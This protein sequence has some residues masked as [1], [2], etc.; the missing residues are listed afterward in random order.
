[1]SIGVATYPA[2]GK[3]ARTL[4]SNADAALYR[5]KAEGPGS[6]FLF[7]AEMAARLHDRAALEIELRSAIQREEFRLHYQPQ[8]KMTGE[9]V[10]FEALARWH[11]PTRGSV[12][13]TTFIP[14]A[15]ESSLILA[16]GEWV[17]RQACREAAS[18][19]RP[20]RVA[21]N[22][23]PVQFRHGDLA[24][25][26]HSVLLETGLASCRLEL[27][28]TE[29]VLI[30]DFSRA[31]SILRRIKS[32]GVQ[33]VL[34]DFGSKYSSLSYLRAFPF[35]KIKIDRSFISNLES[36]HQSIAIVRAIIGLGHGL[37]IPVLAEGVETAVQHAFLAQEGCDEVQGYLT[38]RPLAIAEYADVVGHRMIAPPSAHVGR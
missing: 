9:I 1:L 15:E 22:V 35:D 18:W 38:G 24:G 32:L 20:L 10:A 16:I 25:L 31:V 7:E 26:V 27:E 4:M 28:V 33:V 13:P 23:S 14:L 6:V 30:D 19:D 21:V 2:H 34:D 36:D 37:N 3:D 12:P 17:L 29:N 5:A 8:L 11:S